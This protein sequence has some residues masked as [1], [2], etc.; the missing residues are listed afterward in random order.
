MGL[1]RFLKIHKAS[2]SF[3]LILIIF[4]AS[5]LVVIRNY[6]LGGIAVGTLGFVEPEKTEESTDGGIIPI[7]EE[8]ELVGFEDTIEMEEPEEIDII[9]IIDQEEII[10]RV[11]PLPDRPRIISSGDNII[12]KEEYAS[13][14][15]GINCGDG[16][17][18]NSENPF[19]CMIDCEKDMELYPL[20]EKESLFDKLKK[21]FNNIFKPVSLPIVP[22]TNGTN[23]TNETHKICYGDNC[24]TVQGIGIDECQYNYQCTTNGT[25]QTNCIDNDI[26][27][28]YPGSYYVAS[29]TSWA[30]GG[31]GCIDSCGYPY[32]GI[33]LSECYCTPE[34][35]ATI[36]HYDCLYGCWDNACLV[37]ETNQTQPNNQSDIF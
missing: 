13:V 37:N 12:I 14:L 3:L 28:G 31:I 32:N 4:S 16:I 29:T 9:D 24:I 1:K 10:D 34:G 30:S 25:N 21:F 35:G 20:V 23:Q 36:I 5:F 7:A 11:K 18:D 26:G 27:Y 15:G 17:C 2:L 22:S 33:A 8:A 6:N 19:N